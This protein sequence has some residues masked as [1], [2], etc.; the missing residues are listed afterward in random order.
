MIVGEDGSDEDEPNKDRPDDDLKQRKLGPPLLMGK[1]KKWKKASPSRGSASRS[2]LIKVMSPPPPAVSMSSVPA[3]DVA[4]SSHFSVPNAQSP[5]QVTDLAIVS[6][7][8]IDSALA[9]FQISNFYSD[10]PSQGIIHNI[11]NGMWS[12]QYRDVSVLKMDGNAFLFRIPNISTRN[13]VINQRLWQI[14]GQTMFIDPRKPLPEAVNVQ[15]DSGEVKRVLVSSCNST[16][17]S[18]DYCPRVKTS[19]TK[20]LMSSSPL[21][22]RKLQVEARKGL[23]P[24]DSSGL[25]DATKSIVSSADAYKVSKD[26]CSEVEEDSSYVLSS[27]HDA[28]MSLGDEFLDFTE[29]LFRRRRTGDFYQILDPSEHSSLQDFNVNRRMRDFRDCFEAAELSNLVFRGNTFTWWNKSKTRPVAKKLGRV[30][31]NHH[32]LLVFP[33]SLAIFNEPDFSDHACSGAILHQN[34]LLIRTSFK[35]Y[36]FL[37]L[38]QDFLPLVAGHW[39]ACNVTGS[40]MFRLSHKLKSLK[41][42]I[43][44]FSKEN[45]SNLEKRVAEAHANL[46]RLQSRTFR[47]LA[48]PNVFNARKELEAQRVWQDLASAEE[49]FFCRRSSISWLGDGD[50][51][52]SFFHRMA[53][54]K[55]SINQIHHMIGDDGTRYDSQQDIKDHCVNYFYELLGGKVVSTPIV[56]SDMDLLLPYTC[57]PAQKE[58]LEKQFNNE[59]I[60]DAFFSLLKNKTSGPD[61][62]SAEFFEG[63]RPIIGI[64]VSAAVAEFFKSGKLLEHWNTTNLVL[65]PKI[66]NAFRTTD[67]RPISCLNSVYKPSLSS[68]LVGFANASPPTFFVC[69]NGASSGFFKSSKGLRQGDPISPPLFVLSMEVFSMLLSSSW[70]GLQMN[71]DKT[72]MYHAGLNLDEA[73]AI[74][75]YGFE[76][77]NLPIRYLGLPR[78]LR[79]KEYDPLIEKIASRFRGWAVKTLSFAGRAHLIASVIYGAVNFWMTS[80]MIP[81]GCIKKIESLCSRLL[82]FGNIE[83]GRGTKVS[84]SSVCLPKEEGGPLIKLLGDNGPRDLHLP[85][86]SKVKDAVNDSQWSIPSPRS[87]PAVLFHA[88]LTT[89]QVPYRS[90]AAAYGEGRDELSENTS[91][92]HLGLGFSSEALVTSGESGRPPG[93]EPCDRCGLEAPERL[94]SFWPAGHVFTLLEWRSQGREKRTERLSQKERTKE[95]ELIQL[96]E[97]DKLDELASS[98]RSAK[99]AGGLA[100]SASSGAKGCLDQKVLR[101]SGYKRTQPLAKRWIRPSGYDRKDATFRK[102]VPKHSTKCWSERGCGSASISGIGMDS[103]NLDRTDAHATSRSNGSIEGIEGW[104]G[105]T[106][107]LRDGSDPTDR[108][109]YGWIGSDRPIVVRMDRIGEEDGSG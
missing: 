108:S 96:G 35:F 89:T 21:V 41:F 80:F 3:S 72:N 67:F 11:V 17:H 49:S 88:H 99:P 64:E 59:E 102:G 100:S 39:F 4:V 8:L 18:S 56:Q 16:A 43:R 25:S 91:K 90:T 14:E 31:V 47:T 105:W 98:A 57:S 63:C 20:L 51:N 48:L 103:R 12:R 69:V 71:M 107:C 81:L 10:P 97:L 26:T 70:S 44:K 87:D 9:K 93:Y 101:L 23:L 7:D 24:G 61:G 58:F 38:N 5:V 78:K 28:N 13:R 30:L 52:T 22:Q 36:N 6:L 74:A 73:V 55:R 86:H 79:I 82:W 85:L 32:W 106:D 62:Y 34:R 65:I 27:E 33:D 94:H 40:D 54:K 37:L 2:P 42:V 68:L 92:T 29:V 53:A 109:S 83:S 76:V 50:R 19:T 45:Y 77:G 75:R 60:R 104:M 66:T 46:L 95:S 84:W 15:F 1:Q